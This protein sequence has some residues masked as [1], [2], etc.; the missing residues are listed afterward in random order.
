MKLYNIIKAAS[1]KMQIDFEEIT[2]EI[3]HRPTKG[4][5]REDIVKEFLNQYLPENFGITKGVVID[6]EG[7]ESKQQDILIYD[8]STTPKFLTSETETV[9]PI[10][11]V[12]AIVE[13]K[14]NLNK[15]ELNKSLDNIKSVRQMS[16]NYLNKKSNSSYPFGF[17]FSYSSSLKLD[18]IRNEYRDFFQSN[19]KS[20]LPTSIISLDK[21]AV[22]H[23]TKSDLNT[24]E[25]NAS[26]ESTFGLKETSEKGDNL[27]LFYILL[28]ASLFLENSWQVNF[29]DIAMY[30]SK[31]GFIN[32]STNVA[33]EDSQDSKIIL[34]DMTFDMN[35]LKEVTNYF[36]G[37]LDKSSERTVKILEIINEATGGKIFEDD[38]MMKIKK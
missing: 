15:N 23:L 31:S 22:I 2:S 36:K 25:I 17:I 32:P 18:S 5:F 20:V 9:L 21:G 12:I 6:V 38:A 8:K 26:N 3:E 24:V 28:V 27:M 35:K 7:N 10:E 1:K 13:V 19:D 34:D 37:S 4:D 29:P 16:K 30:A 14:S 33:N 11:S